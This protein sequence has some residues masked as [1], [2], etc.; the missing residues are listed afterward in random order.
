MSPNVTV[1][2]LV[3]HAA[4]EEIGLAE[5]A[6]SA[7]TAGARVAGLRMDVVISLLAADD[8]RI[9]ALNAT[10]RDKAVP[11]NV[12]SWPSENLAG[13]PGEAPT[14]PTDPELGDIALSF[15]TCVREASDFGKLFMIT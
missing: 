7:C 10:F 8:A 5:I 6:Q 4:W 3:E 13:L 12:L 11:T 1:D 14:Q 15:E 9:A 2:L